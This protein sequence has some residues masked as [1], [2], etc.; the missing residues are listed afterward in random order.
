MDELFNDLLFS[1][2][3]E[4]VIQIL[5]KYKLWNIENDLSKN[6]KFYGG[7]ESNFSTVTGQTTNPYGA[8]VEKLMN[9]VD[10]NLILECHKKGIDPE[11]KDAPKSL[12]EAV[13]K[14][15]GINDGKLSSLSNDELKVLSENIS[16]VATGKKDNPAFLV[17]DK[18]EG[19]SPNKIE[20]TLLSLN[21]GNKQKIK[22]VQGLHNQGGTAVIRRLGQY[23][24]QLIASKRHPDLLSEE[25]SDLWGFT[26][27]RRAYSEERGGQ[28]RASTLLYLAPNGEI[29]TLKTKKISVL[30]SSD[31]KPYKNELEQ[32]TFLKLYN[33][34]IPR[35]SM[36]HLDLRRQLNFILLSAPLPIKVVDTRD[37]KAKNPS[38]RILGLWNSKEDQFV[39]GIKTGDLDIT[40]IG[41]L[42]YKYGVFQTKETI[43]N[44]TNTEVKPQ[45]KA[46]FRSGAYLTINGQ[47][48]GDIPNF[49]KT[50]CG[51][52]HLEKNLLIDIDISSVSNKVRENITQTDR[53]NSSAGTERDL[54][55]QYLTPAIKNN[56]FLK[57]LNAD[58][59]RKQIEKAVK[60]DDNFEK[61]FE[62][63]LKNSIDFENIMRNL[64]GGK[65]VFKKTMPNTNGQENKPKLAKFPTFFHFEN[66]KNTYIKN[67]PIN[68]EPQFQLITDAQDDYFHRP[69]EESP[70]KIT[71]I[72]D[73]SIRVSHSY[74]TNGRYYIKIELTENAKVGESVEL[75]IN[76]TDENQGQKGQAGFKNKLIINVEKEINNIT[77]ASNKNKDKRKSG[78]GRKSTPTA[79]MPKILTFHLSDRPEWTSLTSLVYNENDK[80]WHGNLDNKYLEHYKT[81]SPDETKLIEFWFFYGLLMT[82]LGLVQDNQ[83]E[84]EI[85]KALRGNAGHIITAIELY[86]MKYE[87]T[88]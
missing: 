49:I 62:N 83:T 7:Q 24:F 76:V 58:L 13:E 50:K 14:F 67:V 66:Q 8:L 70:G 21:K 16:L 82:G 60:S 22:F 40:E 54:I 31:Y 68:N 63:L 36:I 80:S 9:S 53:Q 17:I 6:W 51:L 37:Y 79:D 18:G 64:E 28:Y 23:G 74:L 41:K 15:Y 12:N 85:N 56:P 29:P 55:V 45:L 20:D 61:I 11:S 43:E 72:H 52:D 84:D 35:K 46:E 2:S 73:D 34:D 69:D 4:D 88:E 32:G 44:N 59:K 77:K 1:E 65:F 48:H 87:L 19:Q 47:T 10:A 57:K 71:F 39:E 27:T 30:P 86:K 33:F 5:K 78:D 81:I 38:D 42:K 75:E 3:E 26:L 25:D